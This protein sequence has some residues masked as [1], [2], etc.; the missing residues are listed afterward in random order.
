VRATGARL[1]PSDLDGL[2][3][4]KGDGKWHHFYSAE[5]ALQLRKELQNFEGGRIVIAVSSIPYRCPPAPL[6]FT[7]LLEE[8]LHKRGIR[9]KTKI[10]YLFPLPKIFPIE[11]VAEVV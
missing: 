3:R 5:G 4:C 11:S 6:E 2:S 8:W 1:G 7:F 9:E 10:Q